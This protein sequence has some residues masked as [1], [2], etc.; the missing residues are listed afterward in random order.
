MEIRRT[1]DEIDY[2]PLLKNKS[3]HVVAFAEEGFS[4]FKAYAEFALGLSI[5]KA[6]DLCRRINR[7]D[8][9]G[10]L[11]P[12]GNLTALPRRFFRDEELDEKGFKRCLRDAFIANRDYCKCEHLVF[13]LFC[14][15]LHLDEFFDE[16]KRMAEQEFADAGI[17]EITVHMK[18]A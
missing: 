9:T 6:V 10:T 14:V 3:V 11:W 18:A 4:F 12:T 7:E 16:I 13:Q 1:E 15:Q 5:S 2:I 8:E 17:A